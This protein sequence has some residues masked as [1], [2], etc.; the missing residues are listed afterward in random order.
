MRIFFNICGSP[1][2]KMR[3]GEGKSTVAP[4]FCSNTGMVLVD[5][6]IAEAAGVG[7]SIVVAKRTSS[8]TAKYQ[9]ICCE[10]LPKRRGLHGLP[11]LAFIVDLRSTYH[12]CGGGKQLQLKHDIGY[13]K[14][15]TTATA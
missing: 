10:L 8:A 12:R 4:V 11:R 9:S 5:H 14:K 6:A 15:K 1:T 13:L 7:K 2:S 3:S